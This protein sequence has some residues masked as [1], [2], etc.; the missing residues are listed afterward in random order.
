MYW[1]T[2]LGDTCSASALLSKLPLTLSSGS[3]AVA[4]M[5]SPSRSRTA[6]AY[7]R[8]FRRRSGT[9]PGAAVRGAGV[10][11]VLEPRDEL[12]RGLAV[13]TPRA[14]RRHQAAAQLADHL[15]G[16]LGVLAGLVGVEVVERQ[17]ADLG[18][19]VVAAEAV[20]L[21]SARC[22]VAAGVAGVCPRPSGREPLASTR[23][24]SAAKVPRAVLIP[25]FIFGTTQIH[26]KFSW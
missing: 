12:G 13:G 8:R 23:Q 15:L 6:Y 26:G 16:H 20:L 17:A 21:I 25:R 11:L 2:K 5:S 19:V 10:D 22:G 9:R 24:N 3:Q 7:S 1:L 4:S 14:G 18:L